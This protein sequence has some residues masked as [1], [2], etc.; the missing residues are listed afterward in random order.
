[1]EPL[2]RI[3]AILLIL[4]SSL[5]N[6]TRYNIHELSPPSNPSS[7]PPP[8]PASSAF[9]VQGVVLCQQCSLVGTPSLAFSKPLQG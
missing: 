9:A 5:V 3:T 8:P 1:M 6:A 4:A 7:Y 2:I